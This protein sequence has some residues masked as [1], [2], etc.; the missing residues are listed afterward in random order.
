MTITHDALAMFYL[1]EKFTK[2]AT[3]VCHTISKKKSQ[4][5]MSCGTV[6]VQGFHLTWKTWKNECTP[7]KP[8]NIVEF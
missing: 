6:L 3:K 7:G 8:G 1:T 4:N 5:R 2:M